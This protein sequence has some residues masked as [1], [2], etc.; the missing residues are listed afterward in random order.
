MEKH[1][2]HH[3]S[4]ESGHHHHH[5]HSIFGRMRF[6]FLLNLAF[7]IIELI[8]GI[9]TNS[10]AILSDALHD[11]GD[12]MAMVIA[13]TL[14]KISHKNSDEAYSYGY[15]RF[16]TLGA[17]I[18]GFILI[19]GSCI[20]LSEAIPR[21]LNPQQPHTNGM[22]AL[23]ILGLAVNG[24]AAFRI[25][26][27][28]SLNEKMLMWH[29]VEDV[30]GWAVVLVGAIVMKFFDI[31]QLD[32]GLAIAVALWI[33]YNVFKNLREAMKVFL[34]ASPAGVSV[35]GAVDAIRKVDRVVDVHHAH[36]WSLDGEN[37]I[38]TAHVVLGKDATNEETALV[39][40]EVKA[41]L[42]T[43]GIVE[44]TIETEVID[45]ACLDPHHA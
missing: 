38:F 9:M 7:A 6:A 34:M 45:M 14:E 21:L 16:S 23:A 40:N 8:G 43:F 31:P 15:R 24:Y 25:S 28:T 12:A 27:G 32:A 26:K 11:F 4:H 33:L 19:V 36:L 39:K 5:S 10:V 41:L 30:L 18:T 37:H 22:I 2:H 42:R 29:M 1:P 13:L 17:V 20:I 35:Q 3:H 44:A